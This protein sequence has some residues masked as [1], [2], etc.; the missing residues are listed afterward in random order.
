[1]VPREPRKKTRK[2]ASHIESSSTPDP[3]ADEEWE[4]L[5]PS[6]APDA[7]TDEEWES[8]FRRSVLLRP[9]TTD[10]PPL[11]DLTAALASGV[12]E[13]E[14]RVTGSRPRA[15]GESSAEGSPLPAT[16]DAEGAP[17]L[18]GGARAIRRFEITTAPDIPGPGADLSTEPETRTVGPGLVTEIALERAVDA[19][20]V[21]GTDAG[22]GLPAEARG[23]IDAELLELDQ[24]GGVALAVELGT[25]PEP[26]WAAPELA[27]GESAR[28]ALT[29]E[30]WRERFFKRGQL[31]GLLEGEDL[32]ILSAPDVAG[33]VTTLRLRGQTL[34]T[35]AAAALRQT[36]AGFDWRDHD[37]L[38]LL[39]I[40]LDW[41]LRGVA[42]ESRPAA[43]RDA[44]RGMAERYSGLVERLT[45]LLPPR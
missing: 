29:E 20:V 10:M 14:A 31:T 23:E 6:P 3:N 21:R 36:P 45:A 34:T 4:A 26:A 15:E 44:V 11:H 22:A 13:I 33:G 30:E 24:D 7:I 37:D 28:V 25:E 38:V 19:G 2:Q 5:Q 27:A 18:G 43:V 40:V 1:M 41:W 32:L 8:L 17:D 16:V 42:L 12:L 39:G 9:L 35:V